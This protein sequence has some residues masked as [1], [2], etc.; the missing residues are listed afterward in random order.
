M[1]VVARE[2]YNHEYLLE[3]SPQNHVESQMSTESEN[4]EPP[5]KRRS[6]IWT[7][8]LSDRYKWVIP[9]RR[10]LIDWKHLQA[11]E[12]ETEAAIALYQKQDDVSV[13]FHY[14]TTSRNSIDGEWESIILN[15]SDDRQYSLRSIYFAYEYRKNIARLICEIY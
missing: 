8:E 13:T 15:F 5:S 6:L 3:P 12:A 11:T 1:Q 2:L 4:S 7:P 9:Y 10:T 14:D